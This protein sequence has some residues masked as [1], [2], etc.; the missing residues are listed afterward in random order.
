[1]AVYEPPEESTVEALVRDATEVTTES[2]PGLV[3][4]IRSRLEEA[5]DARDS[6]ETR[7]LA[8]HRN[9]RGVYNSHQ[10]DSKLRSKVFVKI[11][12][13]KVLAAY[14]QIMEIL[15]SAGKFP[16]SVE[17]TI[18]PEG[19]AKYAHLDPDGAGETEEEV[20]LFGFSGDGKEMLPGASGPTELPNA[21]FLGGLASQYS[22]AP[23]VPGPAKSGEP[24]IE[25]A[26]LAAEAMQRRIHD[27]LEAAN[28]SRAL[29]MCIFECVLLGTGIIKGPFNRVQTVHKW[30]RN[31]EGVR[32]YKPYDKLVPGLNQVSCWDWY[33]DPAGR[34]DEELGW[35][36]QRHKLNPS[37]MRDLIKLPHF[38]EKEL[39]EV[40]E[41][42]PNYTKRDYE[43]SLYHLE[44]A[45]QFEDNDRWE[46]L[47]YWGIMDVKTL[48]EAGIE[49]DDIKDDM[50][51][52]QVNVW[53]SGQ[54][55]LRAVVNP[56]TPA[57]IP[58]RSVPYEINPYN[59]FG[60][61]VPENMDDAQ[62]I[63]NGHMRM[64]IDNLALAGNMVFDVDENMMVAGQTYDIYP[65]KVFRR[66]SGNPG[67][68]IFGLKFP[69]TAPENVQ[70]YDKGRQ[71]ADEETGIPSVM[72]GQTGVSGTGRTASGLS[73]LMGAA[74]VNIKTVVKNVDD[75]ILKPLGEDYY[76]WNMQFNEDDIDI[77]GDLEIKATGT[78]ALMQKEV[79]SQRLTTL[80][81]TV[82][83]PM[84]ASFVKIPNL[85]REL[86]LTMDIE[87]DSMVNDM[88]EAAI[89]AEIL[90][91]MN[92]Q[93][94]SGAEAGAPGG[95][96]G[97]GGGPGGAPQ[98]A[99]PGAGGA[100]SGGNVGAGG[101]PAPG[102]TGFTGNG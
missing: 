92:V 50:D 86:A 47:E 71:L 32:E 101:V 6:D 44:E 36:I 15:F 96:P 35:G 76:H 60:I 72:H 28:A 48:D 77:V 12:K 80:L 3:G 83:N 40:L 31:E 68:G 41:Q 39:K 67:Q 51:E 34:N 22:G 66:K 33:P 99:N 21:H 87:P 27:Q 17:E 75:Y 7:W 54:N 53:I 46:V 63:M 73:M 18:E 94:G 82:A 102:E 84:L 25:P 1:M 52:V 13:V 38:R 4:L 26:K 61:G 98:G 64:A 56:F 20:D 24:Q 8:A 95:Q 89:Q 30:E 45:T 85:M 55:I 78:N 97:G 69:N 19:I 10:S 2:A 16:I 57:R 49:L 81:Q 74:G 42:G 93:Q 62:K 59:Y 43:D 29:S 11:T 79:R 70:M 5:E 23:L 14:G 100:A 37:Q 65:G 88:N 58:Y 91:G 9:Y 90:R